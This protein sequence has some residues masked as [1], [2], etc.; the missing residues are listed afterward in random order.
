MAH[1][2]FIDGKLL[3]VSSHG[4]R[5]EAAPR[6][7]FHKPPNLL[8]EDSTLRT[9]QEKCHLSKVPLPNTN[10]LRVRI[11]TQEFL[12]SVNIHSTVFDVAIW[13]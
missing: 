5:G 10:T 6:G 1:F 11:S 4:R 2:L 12:E 9:F 3:A 8:P 7:L 13:K